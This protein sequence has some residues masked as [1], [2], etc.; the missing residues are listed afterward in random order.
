MW[1]L[2]SAACTTRRLPTSTEDV[3]EPYL[4]QQGYLARAARGRAATHLAYAH[5]G[6]EQPTGHR[7]MF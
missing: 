4:I 1:L 2:I 7:K 5:L 3:Y 6:I